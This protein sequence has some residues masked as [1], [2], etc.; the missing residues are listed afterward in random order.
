MPRDRDWPLSPVLDVVRR[1]KELVRESV[2]TAEIFCGR[3]KG[4]RYK[5][6]T[7]VVPEQR[8]AKQPEALN[9]GIV[10]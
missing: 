8:M 5:R 4:L 10:N 7:G 1:P 2:P 9:F 3:V 6:P